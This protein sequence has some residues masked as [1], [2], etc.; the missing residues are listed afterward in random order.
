M[1]EIPLDRRP[2]AGPQSPRRREVHLEP[3]QVLKVELE[4][5]D[6][7]NT[8]LVIKGD[9]DVNVTVWTCLVPGHG[10]EYGQIK[11]GKPL[12]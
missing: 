12:P 10:T 6:L 1:D 9:Q 11:Y 8:G 2:D 7:E 3:E 4:I 5:H